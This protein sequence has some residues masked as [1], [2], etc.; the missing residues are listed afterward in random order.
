MYLICIVLKLDSRSGGVAE[1]RENFP[2][3]VVKVELVG[4]S[5]VKAQKTRQNVDIQWELSAAR[6]EDWQVR[7]EIVTPTVLVS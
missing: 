3:F 6:G 7:K 5:L 1:R 2:V 4:S